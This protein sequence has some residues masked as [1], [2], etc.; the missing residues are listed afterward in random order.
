MLQ[1]MA[2]GM[3]RIELLSTSVGIGSKKLLL[4]QTDEQGAFLSCIITIFPAGTQAA[5]KQRK[6][7]LILPFECFF[8]ADFWVFF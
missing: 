7:S 3:G 5:R 2:M 1:A 6:I 8:S 4:P